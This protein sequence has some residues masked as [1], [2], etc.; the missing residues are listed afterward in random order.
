MTITAAQIGNMENYEADQMRIDSERMAEELKLYEFGKWKESH[1]IM[2]GYPGEVI[3]IV[4][5]DGFPEGWAE[6]AAKDLKKIVGDISDAEA[7][8]IDAALSSLP[9][10]QW[11]AVVLTYLER[12]PIRR[13]PERME[14]SRYAAEKALNQGLGMMWGLL[15]KVA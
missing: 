14:T 1:G 6:D 12:T 10:P 8:R 11:R 4:I 7:M 15:K 5:E 2:L 3:G 13:L 9:L